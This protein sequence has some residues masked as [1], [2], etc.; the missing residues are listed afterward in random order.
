MHLLSSQKEISH[1]I[2]N[3]VSERCE[4]SFYLERFPVKLF[5]TNY[6][7]L[8]YPPRWT[9]AHNLQLYFNLA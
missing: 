5:L 6:F 4:E 8:V 7:P 9:A 1:L 3:L 2:F